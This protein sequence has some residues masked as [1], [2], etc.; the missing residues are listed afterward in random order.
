MGAHPELAPRIAQVPGA[1]RIHF[2]LV[3]VPVPQ[4]RESFLAATD[5]GSTLTWEGELGTDFGRLGLL[6]VTSSNAIISESE[7]RSVAKA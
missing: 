5:S 2:H 7:R 1:Q 3:R 4:V 6:G